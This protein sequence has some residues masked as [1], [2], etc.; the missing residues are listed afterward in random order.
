[1]PNENTSRND[2]DLDITVAID[3]EGM[4]TIMT[5]AFEEKSVVSVPAAVIYEIEAEL[6][7][8]I[9]DY[10]KGWPNDRSN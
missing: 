9:P 3:P 7:R 2:I 1:M 5:V 4:V 8:V 10:V 6:R